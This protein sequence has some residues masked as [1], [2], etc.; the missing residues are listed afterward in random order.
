MVL[1]SIIQTFLK[2]QNT[3]GLKTYIP[4]TLLAH[5][6]DCALC[7]FIAIILSF[8]SI[9]IPS[10]LLKLCDDLSS[11]SIEDVSR[12]AEKMSIGDIMAEQ[13]KQ[14]KPIQ[15]LL[16]CAIYNW[17]CRNPLATKKKLA[18]VLYDC[19]FLNEAIAM[20]PKCKH[21]YMPDKVIR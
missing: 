7:N 16:F 13:F 5:S 4:Y 15:E 12:L 18:E 21:A 20:D 1:S 11:L 14:N 6:I 10:N 19:K 3:C 8:R 17:H 9:L 2:T